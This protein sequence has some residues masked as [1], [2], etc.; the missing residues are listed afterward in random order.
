MAAQY[1]LVEKDT[2]MTATSGTTCSSGR[3]QMVGIVC[4]YSLAIKLI[5]NASGNS[6]RQ[7]ISC[8]RTVSI[9][10]EDESDGAGIHIAEVHPECGPELE[11]R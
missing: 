9:P 7:S 5:F 4:S 10:I 8:E 1:R 2:S 6:L 11:K 3:F